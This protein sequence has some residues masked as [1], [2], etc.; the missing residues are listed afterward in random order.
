MSV[1]ASSTRKRSSQ[2]PSRD[3]TCLSSVGLQSERRPD[4]SNGALISQERLLPLLQ[5]VHR[6]IDT[7]WRSGWFFWARKAGVSTITVA[8]LQAKN[9]HQVWFGGLLGGP[10]S[11]SRGCSQPSSTGQHP[12][13]NMLVPGAAKAFSDY[14]KYVFSPYI[15]SQL[16]HVNR[17]DVVWDEYFPESLKV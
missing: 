7:W 4:P 5:A 6:I 12:I 11:C 8:T 9:W 10:G 3:T 15:K 1:S 16:H 17:V 13:V 2:I 14:V